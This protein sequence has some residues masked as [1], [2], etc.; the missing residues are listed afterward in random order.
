MPANDYNRRFAEVFND[1]KNYPSIADVAGALGK[2]YQTIRNHAAILRARHKTDKSSPKLIDRSPVRRKIETPQLTPKQHA[3][4]RAE[5]LASQM[6]ALLRSSRY[7]VI[8]PEAMVI[9]SH[10]TSRYDRQLARHIEAEGTPR[11]WLTDT[12]R[13]KPVKAARNKRYIFSGAQ[14]DAPVHEGFWE[15]LKAYAECIGAEIVIGPWTYETN[16]WDE[17]NPAS[18]S[19][20]DR[21]AEYLCFGQMAIGSNFVFCGE[22]NTLPT[23]NRPISDLTTYS[24][25]RWAVFPHA[26]LQLISVPA[27]DPSQQAFQVMTTGAVTRPRVIPRKAGIKSIFHQ[28]IGATLVEFDDTGDLFARQLNADEDGSFYDLDAYVSEGDVTFG[29]RARALTVGDIHVAKINGTNALATFG[30]N[31]ITGAHSSGSIVDHL[32]PEYIF[33]HDLHDHEARNHHHKDD[34]SHNFEMAIRGRDNVMDEVRKGVDFLI[35]AQRSDTRLVVVES[36]HDLALERYI[37]EG[38]YRMDGINYRDG[39][40][41][42]LAYHDYRVAA[43]K[44]LD[45][46]KPPPTFSLLEWAMRHVGGAKINNVEWVHDGGSFI[47]DEV[48]LGSHGFRGANGSFGT[49]AGFARLGQKMTIGDKHSPAILDGV[50]VAGVMSL[51]HGY[52]KGP[53]GWAVAHVVQYKNGKRA[54]I[55]MQNGKFRAAQHSAMK[56]AA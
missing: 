32:A 38:R 20:D 44:A 10:I 48:Q 47:L 37:R 27:S 11:T 22:M 42:D 45:E 23:A 16:W 39:L 33:L 15:N 29:H 6:N 17:N 56:R 9:Q 36:N 7:P 31:P 43:G 3:R 30:F 1:T 40:M 35:K 52:N 26:R 25:G 50:Y 13:V 12:L 46:G 8:N 49:V 54:L 53:S 41:L 2:S 21:I 51:D 34:V 4:V 24:G 28:V 18:R 19:Y 14:N 5:T 55:T